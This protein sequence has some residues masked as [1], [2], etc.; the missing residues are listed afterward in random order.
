M[1]WGLFDTPGLRSG[2]CVAWMSRWPAPCMSVRLP[3]TDMNEGKDASS[4]CEVAD[5]GILDSCKCAW[6]IRFFDV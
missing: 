3:K 6:V 4:D 5:T 1:L 2:A